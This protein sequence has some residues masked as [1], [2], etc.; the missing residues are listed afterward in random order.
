MAA[1]SANQKHINGALVL[2]Q[3]G[4]ELRVEGRRN[5]CVIDLPLAAKWGIAYPASED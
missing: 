5:R 3:H 2:L 4:I 1:R